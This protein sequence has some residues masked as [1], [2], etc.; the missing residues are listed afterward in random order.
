MRR[1]LSA[2]LPAIGFTIVFVALAAL[3]FILNSGAIFVVGLAIIE[4]LFALSWNLLFT[5]SGIASFGHAAFFAIGAYLVACAQ[6]YGWPIGFPV[7]LVGAFA[8][9]AGA[10]FV[11][12]AAALRRVSGIHFAIL[13]LAVAE[14][15]R[16]II[17]Y[18]SFLG[19]DEGIAGIPRPVLRLGIVDI[20]L[21]TSSAYFWFVLLA[22][23]L[24]ALALWWFVRSESGRTLR[25]LSLDPERAA[26]IGIDVYRYRL[27][28]FTIS[29]GVAAF[30]GGLSA[31]WLQIVT[32]DLSHWAHSAQP[33]LNTLLGGAGSFWGPVVGA[34]VYAGLNYATRTL[35]GASELVIG[36]TL[37]VII[38]VAPAGISGAVETARRL[39]LGS[40]TKAPASLPMR[41]PSP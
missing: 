40:E 14:V 1:S 12:G 38:L 9:G 20:A 16:T 35:A 19:R 17:S 23:G 27:L 7:Q 15:V 11:L 8:L 4:G 10:A 6:R 22:C 41:G 29:G 3:P 24:V 31:P 33:M 34:F 2:S 32:P 21:R 13:T 5:Y 37:L 25:S 36:L 30:C 39:F 26:F 28:A 18:T